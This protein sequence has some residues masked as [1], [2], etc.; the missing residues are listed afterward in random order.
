[1]DA[2]RL[3]AY[4]TGIPGWSNAVVA[5]VEL[6][7]EGWESTIY[8]FTAT[9]PETTLHLVLRMYTGSDGSYKAQVESGG[10]PRL[11][12]M[13]YPVPQVFVYEL[14]TT[15][16][17]LPFIVM[18][19]IIGNQLWDEMHRKPDRRAAYEK[20]LI[21]LLVELHR[22]D[23]KPFLGDQPVPQHSHDLIRRDLALW[24]DLVATTPASG[25]D[26]DALDWFDTRLAAVTPISPAVVHNDF[27]PGNILVTAETTPVVIDWSGL[28]VGD[29]RSDLAWTLMLMEFVDGPEARQR[30]QSR[31]EA[32]LSTADLDFFMAGA[33]VKRL[34][35]LVASLTHG[36]ET[37][38]MRAEAAN[39]MRNHLERADGVYDEF[40]RITGHR[41][42]GFEELRGR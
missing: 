3:Q 1:M 13:G 16:L 31:Y 15:T 35:S 23:W 14:D 37:L 40:R 6:I 26:N 9:L 5:D 29:P 38:G 22:L 7:G 20:G 28:G 25:F 36:P 12:A 24:R 30:I 4:L 19:R 34:Y 2:T 41:L 32:E 10:M 17:G 18:E 42:A 21:D 33:Y 11:R 27:H 8:A 39:E